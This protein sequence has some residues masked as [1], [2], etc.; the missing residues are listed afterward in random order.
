MRTLITL[1]ICLFTGFTFGQESERQIQKPNWQIGDKKRI[2]V[3]V[4]S[5]GRH[6]DM[7]PM[8]SNMEMIHQIE[9]LDTT[10]EY[11]IQYQSLNEGM[12][13]D[14]KSEMKDFNAELTKMITSMFE[15]VGTIPIQLTLDKQNAMG[16]S[17]VDP[18]GF[19]TVA[20]QMIDSMTLNWPG[21]TPEEQE[22]L[23]EYLYGTF[24]KSKDDM[25]LSMTRS[26]DDLFTI[27]SLEYH[28]DSSLKINDTYL[29]NTPYAPPTFS[30]HVPAKRSISTRMD[31]NVLIMKTE[32]RVDPKEIVSIMGR[33]TGA[34][35][36]PSEVAIIRKATYHFDTKTSWLIS[37]EDHI[38]QKTGPEVLELTRKVSYEDVD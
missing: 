7:E 10:E 2:K 17:L 32:Q 26:L 13:I 11:L 25:F 19:W 33:Y 27:Y 4:T 18:E 22:G 37:S 23:R 9:V 3:E 36:E 5:V 21:F 35:L 1:T 31:G 15:A 20:E 30:E 6:P 29:S 16:R 28:L 38:V 12:K 14:M 24:S 8:T 34:Y